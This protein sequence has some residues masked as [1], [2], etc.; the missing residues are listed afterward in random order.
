MGQVPAATR[1]LRVLRFLAGQPDP[2][3]LDRL[4]DRG[5]AC[6]AR[7]PTTWCGAMIE[8]GFVVHLPDEH[9][10]GLGVAAFEVGTGY[11]RQEPLQ[12]ITRRHLAALVDTRR[13]E[14][15]PRGAARPRRALRPGGARSR[16]AAAGHRRRRAA[17]GP[18]DRERPGDPRGA[19]GG[20]GARALP[21]PDAFVDRH[22]LGPQL[23][24]RAALAAVRDPAARLRHRGGRGDPG[25]RLGRRGGARPQPAPGG[26]GGGHLRRRADPPADLRRTIAAT[27]RTAA[28]LTAR[29]GGS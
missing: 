24:Q 18:P 2:V 21:R 17:A 5:R 3:T 23:A 16:A 27:R 26:R 8:E 12:R 20:P 6:R 29:L 9:R 19:A 1:A 28:T 13:A 14:R 15:A 10:Y 25:L 4:A 11:A 22:G 7:R